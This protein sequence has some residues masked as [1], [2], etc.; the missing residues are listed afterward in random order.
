MRNRK[1]I[2]DAREG[3]LRSRDRLLR[4]KSKRAQQSLFTALLKLISGLKT[5]ENDV[6]TYGSANFKET[7]KVGVLFQQFNRKN[8]KGLIAWM[9]NSLNK[10]LGLN[11]LY[12][13]SVDQVNKTI[14]GRARRVLFQRLGYDTGG[15]KIIPGS[16]LFNLGSHDQ[17]KIQVMRD[18]N[19]A[20][21]SGITKKQFIDQFEQAFL[22]PG[23]LGYIERYYDQFV[24]DL[25]MSSDRAVQ[26]QIASD[27]GFEFFIYGGTVIK[28][29]RTFCEERNNKV[30]HKSEAIDWQNN[31][32]WK[33]KK[34]GHQIFIDLGGYRCRHSINW[35]PTSTA[36]RL[37]IKQRGEAE[38]R[39]LFEKNNLTFDD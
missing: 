21:A 20:L 13:K 15:K 32:T 9:L 31:L 16:W 22:N 37:L 19:N 11:R 38:A 26:N 27:L 24:G 8:K 7:Q 6:L 17:V 18:I 36:K 2:E 28:T 29:T 39:A 23:G 34:Q 4:S 35:I 12:F 25:F 1:E 30:Y 3:F 33:G 10:I 5:D 14:E